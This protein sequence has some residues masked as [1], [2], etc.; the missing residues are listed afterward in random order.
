MPTPSG[1][2]TKHE[3]SV[4]PSEFIRYYQAPGV[5]H[6]VGAPGADT[7]N[8]VA[9]LDAWGSSAT[10]PGTLTRKKVNPTN[11]ATVFSRPLCL[12]PKYPRYNGSGD[13][14]AAASYT[15]TWAADAS[16]NHHLKE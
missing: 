5:A 15:C 4:F 7:V 13:V 12:H 10:A 9:P 16:P 1:D 11:G 14:N 3:N 6:C 8:L 2:E